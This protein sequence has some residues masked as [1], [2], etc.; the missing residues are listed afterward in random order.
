L[1]GIPGLPGWLIEEIESR[2]AKN[3]ERRRR[4]RAAY[5]QAA[6]ALDAAGVEF[7]LLKG[8]T[9]EAGFGIDPSAR[10]QYDL[11]ILTLP[12]DVPLARGALENLDYAPHGTQSLSDEHA[13]PLVQSSNW[14]WRGDYYDPEMPIPVELH[15]SPW[16]AAH[17]RIHVAGMEEFWGRRCCMEVNGLRIPA[18]TGVDRLAFA[19]LHVLRHIL[20]HDAKPAHVLELATFLRTHESDAAFWD[21]WRSLHPPELR[22]LQTVAFRF[23]HEWFGSPLPADAE[24]P[25]SADAWFD[26]F[27]WSPI[28]NLTRPNKDTVWLHLALLNR[29]PDRIRVFCHRLFPM[30]RPHEKF[31]TRLRYHARA[32]APALANGLRGWRRRDAA[33]TAS[34]I[35]DWKRRNV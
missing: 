34:E 12:T 9:H 31:L 19:A 32:L 14:K 23:A 4:L 8:F 30:R 27:A 16:S 2:F 11:D 24:Q 25:K 21:E 20:R 15:G 3:A 28:A 22:M 35:S 17:D 13:R 26:D 33:S 18:F 7:V 29:W 6:G 1:R 10:V 5:I